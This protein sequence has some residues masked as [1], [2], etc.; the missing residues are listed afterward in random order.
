MNHAAAEDKMVKITAHMM[1][2][3]YSVN[4]LIEPVFG[5]KNIAL[6]GIRTR[7]VP[8]PVNPRRVSGTA[9]DLDSAFDPK[10][11]HLL[12]LRRYSWGP[13][14]GVSKNCSHTYYDGVS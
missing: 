7:D 9:H 5:E 8:P 13:T 11:T 4:E 14:V 10:F 12:I 3:Y 6:R 2:T 1:Y